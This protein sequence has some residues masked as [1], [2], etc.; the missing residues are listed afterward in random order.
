[1][2]QKRKRGRPRKDPDEAVCHG[3]VVQPRFPRKL[4]RE[5]S[6]A[7]SAEGLPITAWIKRLCYLAVAERKKT[8]TMPSELKVLLQK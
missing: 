8:I 1:M 2:E 3:I 7:A 5:V 6:A 4:H